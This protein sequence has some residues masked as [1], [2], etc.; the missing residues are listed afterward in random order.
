MLILTS[1][2]VLSKPELEAWEALLRNA[3][4]LSGDFAMVIEYIVSQSF[5]GK[6]VETWYLFVH[7][8]RDTIYRS[9]KGLDHT[10]TRFHF[11]LRSRT[12]QFPN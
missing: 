6:D 12:R 3:T 11:D 10:H 7:Y 8:P 5:Q 1:T 4:T 9:Y 2:W